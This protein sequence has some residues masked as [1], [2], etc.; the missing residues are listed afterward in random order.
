MYGFWGVLLWVLLFY[1]VAE[2][3]EKVCA[4]CRMI[5]SIVALLTTVALSTSYHRVIDNVNF[6]NMEMNYCNGVSGDSDW[7]PVDFGE[8]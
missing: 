6:M 7:V 3:A 1:S 5:N 2:K 8:L 4:L